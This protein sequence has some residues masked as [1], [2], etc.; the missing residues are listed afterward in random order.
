MADV[1]FGGVMRGFRSGCVLMVAGAMAL[2][3]ASALAQSGQPGA[4]VR[5]TSEQMHARMMRLL[6]D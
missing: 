4:P 6:G 1:I 3:G 5:M 2:A